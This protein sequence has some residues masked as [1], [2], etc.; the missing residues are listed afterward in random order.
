MRNGR[1]RRNLK[2]STPEG[3]RLYALITPVGA[4]VHIEVRPLEAVQKD[5]P[6]FAVGGVI[7]F[8]V[9]R[10]KYKEVLIGLTNYLETLMLKELD[11]EIEIDESLHTSLGIDP[12][13]RSNKAAPKQRDNRKAIG[14]RD[15]DGL[16]DSTRGGEQAESSGGGQPGSNVATG[17][18]TKAGTDD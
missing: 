9:T 11:K 10:D 17:S 18:D 2:V 4:T 12:K 1:Y 6:P 5:N 3:E 8:Y 13:R 16:H 15:I 14:E 7:R